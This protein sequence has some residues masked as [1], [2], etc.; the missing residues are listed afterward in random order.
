MKRLLGLLVVIGMLVGLPL[1]HLALAKGKPDNTPT[2]ICHQSPDVEEESG[3]LF[4]GVVITVPRH[5]ADKH[6]ERHGDC[7]DFEEEGNLCICN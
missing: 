5:T 3:G 2:T 4:T 1:S 7:E 6:I